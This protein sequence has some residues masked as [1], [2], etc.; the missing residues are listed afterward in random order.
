MV[1]YKITLNISISTKVSKKNM[2]ALLKNHGF[3]IFVL[4]VD[5]FFIGWGLH[6]TYTVE[7][8]W[9]L[10]SITGGGRPKMPLCV[11]FQI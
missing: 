6:C 5:F 11:L 3:Y 2:P 4:I 10:S 7:I 1:L 9:R 8:K